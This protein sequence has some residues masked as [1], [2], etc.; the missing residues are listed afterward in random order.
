MITGAQIRQMRRARQPQGCTV[1][2]LQL[3]A[4]AKVETLEHVVPEGRHLIVFAPKPFLERGPPRLGWV[5][6]ARARQLCLEP[7]NS[8]TSR[9]AAAAQVRNNHLLTT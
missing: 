8:V 3:L 1:E 6:L 5:S 9:C 2:K 4:I 7:T